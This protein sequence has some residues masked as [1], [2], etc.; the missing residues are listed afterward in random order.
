MR[1]EAV[2][3]FVQ[4]K[5]NLFLVDAVKAAR[6]EYASQG[7]RP[8]FIDAYDKA[9]LVLVHVIIIEAVPIYK[10]ARNIDASVDDSGAGEKHCKER[11]GDRKP[12]EGEAYEGERD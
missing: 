9:V 7:V 6:A 11:G 12:Y 2:A 8:L 10:T 5:F 3:V 1:K 4:N